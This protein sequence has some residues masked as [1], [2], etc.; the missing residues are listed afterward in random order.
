MRQTWFSVGPREFRLLFQ[1]APNPEQLPPSTTASEEGES[2]VTLSADQIRA[3]DA[4]REARLAPLRAAEARSRE[5]DERRL[6]QIEQQ[7]LAVA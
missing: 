1:S 3:I 5:E 7:M 4:D 2:Y 6:P